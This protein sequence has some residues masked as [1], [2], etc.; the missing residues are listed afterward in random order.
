MP[1]GPQHLVI[2]V[3]RA[4]YVGGPAEFLYPVEIEN[5]EFGKPLIDPAFNALKAK[6]PGASI[7][8]LR[9]AA[10]PGQDI[11]GYPEEN[12][13]PVQVSDDS[14]FGPTRDWDMS[15]VNQGGETML[16]LGAQIHHKVDARSLIKFD[17]SALA[18]DAK[19]SGAQLRLT[20][21]NQPYTGSKADAKIVAYA[22]HQDWTE[23]ES[24]W[25]SFR[26]D[27][28]WITPGGDDGAKD[29]S[30]EPVGSVEIANFP[31][32]D[33]HYRF[34]SIDLTDCVQKWLSG[35]PNYG[36]LLKYAG[37]GCV[38]VCSSEFQDYPFRPT[39][40]LAYSG[41][42]LNVAAA[43]APGE[44]LEA[45]KVSARKIGKPLMVRFYSPTCVVCKGVQDTTFSDSAVIAALKQNYQVVSVN[46]E[47]HAKLAQDWG[48]GG[49]PTVVVLKADGETKLAQIE[50]VTLRN[51]TQFLAVLAKQ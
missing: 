26:K 3:D 29:R 50:S 11:K 15:N 45:A 47:D 37:G 32:R 46:I 40:V 25:N 19:I 6:F 18:K 24:C 23:N 1:P 41:A 21:S 35:E 49:V 30:A 2:R 8:S 13:V 38:K 4:A 28:T 17:L 5:P 48:V 27:A 7:A 34:V 22:V 36:I 12:V 9:R 51:K 14:L 16:G 44:D 20:L 33:E 39:L 10:G 43:P 31:A 42:A